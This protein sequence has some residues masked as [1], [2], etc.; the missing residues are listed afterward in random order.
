MSPQSTSSI[1]PIDT[2]E[3]KPTFSRKLQS[4][5]A[6]RSAPLWLTNATSPSFA[7]DPAKVALRPF[8]GRITPR[9]LGP[10]IRMSWSRAISLISRSSSAPSSPTSRKPADTMMS[11]STPALPHSS[12]MPGTVGAGVA[13][14]ARSTSASTSPI[15][16]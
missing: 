7:I 16:S 4:R 15:C 8:G 6:V 5:I 3:L 1:D 13:M 11:P 9:Q 12:T 10:T 2:N 14:T